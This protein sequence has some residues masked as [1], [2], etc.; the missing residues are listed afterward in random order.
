LRGTLHLILTEGLNDCLNQLGYA[1]T[2]AKKY[3]LK[4]QIYTDEAKILFT[5]ES[6]FELRGSHDDITFM[7]KSFNR[8]LF[9]MCDYRD[10]NHQF[11]PTAENVIW[12]EAGGGLKSAA[13]FNFLAFKN[14]IIEK[15]IELPLQNLCVHIRSTDHKADLN[16]VDYAARKADGKFLLL[17]DNRDLLFKYYSHPKVECNPQDIEGT[18]N[19]PHHAN[20]AVKK[21]DRDIID[22]LRLSLANCSISSPIRPTNVPLTE[23]FS[24]YYLLAL[25]IKFSMPAIGQSKTRAK[26]LND[27]ITGILK[28]G[29]KSKIA[30]IKLNIY[31]FLYILWLTS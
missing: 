1:L 14:S 8:E 27:Q 2:Y 4:T 18:L 20:S 13:A 10:R 24:G 3:E 16:V 23:Q 12:R 31:V 5:F 28:Y 21:T 30:L 22:L 11:P 29:Q 6:V 25:I 19:K 15:V 17:S 7:E 26:L 9:S